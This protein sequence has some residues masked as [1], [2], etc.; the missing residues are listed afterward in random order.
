[1]R[2]KLLDGSVKIL[3][4]I[5]HIPGLKR[6]FISVGTLDKNGCSYKAEGGVLKVTRGSMVLMKG[7][8][9]QG[10]Y[11]LQETTTHGDITFIE[12]KTNKTELWH[13]RI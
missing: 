6:N 9:V 5:R 11:V 4:D 12:S 13:K 8:L 1:M 3:T 7:L 2:I 10:L